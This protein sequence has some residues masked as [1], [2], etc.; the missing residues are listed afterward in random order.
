[1]HVNKKASNKEKKNILPG[2]D[3]SLAR[4]GKK[5]AA[6]VKRVIGRGMD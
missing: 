6:P 1:M 5:Q 4:P 2:A 3:K